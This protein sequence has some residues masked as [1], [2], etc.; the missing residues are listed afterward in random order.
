MAVCWEERPSGRADQL[1][2]PLDDD[3]CDDGC[4]GVAAVTTGAAGAVAAVVAGVVAAVVAGV[5]AAVV[6]AGVVVVTV[7]P[8]GRQTASPGWMTV[9]ADDPLSVY[10]TSTTTEAPLAIPVHESPATTV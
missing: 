5:V 9:A 2:P 3:C 6:G 10:S 8:A 4:A 1:L 7:M